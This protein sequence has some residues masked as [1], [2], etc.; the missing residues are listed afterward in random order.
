LIWY[1]SGKKYLWNF[2]TCWWN[3]VVAS[4]DYLDRWFDS[5]SIC[6]MDWRRTGLGKWTNQQSMLL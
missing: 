3:Q 1:H 6:E 2:Q 5:T 4:I